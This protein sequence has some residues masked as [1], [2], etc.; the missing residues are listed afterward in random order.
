MQLVVDKGFADRV[1]EN[2]DLKSNL[3]QWF[4]P[5]HVVFNPKKQISLGLYLTVPQNIKEPH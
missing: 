3:K 5:H 1:P 2:E 4:I